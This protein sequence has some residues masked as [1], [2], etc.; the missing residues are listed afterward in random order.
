MDAQAF[1]YGVGYVNSVSSTLKYE[2]PEE[3]D[4]VNRG[5]GGHRV[6]DLYARIKAD[7]W[8]HNPDVIS[9]LIGINDVWHEIHYGNG[10]ELD[11]FEKVYRMMIEDTKKQLPNVKFI[12]CEPF[13]LKGSATEERYEE[14]CE[15][16][17]YAAV[18]KKL[19]EEYGAPFVALQEKFDEAAEKY[20]AVHYLYD[21]VHPDVAGGK[22]IAEEWLKVFRKEVL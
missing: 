7:V 8:N 13:V 5:I 1:G 16:K 17:K 9:I 22:L 2:N 11:R 12:L 4:I 18:V 6:V 19:A 10:V 15:V 14:F 3:Y 20:G 21:G